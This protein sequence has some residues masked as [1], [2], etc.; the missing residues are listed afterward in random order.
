MNLENI[1]KILDSLNSIKSPY[2]N[3]LIE[4]V[5]NYNELFEDNSKFHINDRVQLKKTPEITNK[6]RWGWLGY[7]D[8]LIEGAK[9][10]VKEVIYYNHN[11]GYLVEFDNCKGG[12]YFSEKWLRVA[13][14]P[15]TCVES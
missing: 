5:K 15:I 2:V 1:N 4:L 14:E 13:I 11:F 7:K 12:F 6:V 10:T 9:G 3:D 8:I